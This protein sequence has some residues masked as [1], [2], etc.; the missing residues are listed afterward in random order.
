MLKKILYTTLLILIAICWW[1]WEWLQYGYFQ[2]KGQFKIILEAQP[3]EEFLEDP[4]YPDSLKNKLRLTQIARKYA[5]DSLGL[6]KS[7]NYTKMFDQK[8]E[9]LLWNLSA[10]E[11]YKLKA[12]QWDYPILGSM[13]YKG[14]FDLEKARE[15][16]KNMK[17]QHYDIRIR[18]VGG[19]STLG[20]LEDPLLSNMLDRSDG[21]LAE[22]IIHELTHATIF[23]KDEVEFN[24]N[25]ASFI[26][27]QGAEQFLISHFGD[28][29]SLHLQYIQEEKDSKKLTK[30]I[31]EGALLLDSLYQTF[32]TDLTIET[33]DSLKIKVL[34]NIRNCL[35]ST[36]FYNDR[37]VHLFDENLPN[38]AYFMA[39]RRYHNQEDS[40]KKLYASYDNNIRL[41]IEGLKEKYGK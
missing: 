36:A 26:G 39:F 18:S 2:A 5:T 14:F 19:W 1:N 22:L 7:G 11:P 9:V 20:F 13:P 27:K 37:Y 29:S 17:E 31:L 24:E 40:L 6:H 30:T 21:A 4:D 25:L 28:S 12:Y 32:D 34:N 15:E 23:I 3:I 38:N 16:A 10:S 35:Q 33:K 8:G 41:M